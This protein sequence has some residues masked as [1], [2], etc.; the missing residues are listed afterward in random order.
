TPEEHLLKADAALSA[1]RY[2]EAAESY[3][4][5][6]DAPETRARAELNLRQLQLET[7]HYAAAAAPAR[8]AEGN[9]EMAQRT[10]LLRAQALLAV[11]DESAALAILEKEVSPQARLLRGEVLINSGKRQAAK[12]ILMS[13]IEDYN[14]D[15]IR[16][17]DSDGMSYVGRAAHLL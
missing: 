13:I 1:G 7:G 16:D 17:S 11:G 3:Q 12:P 8:H 4:V 15:R 5:A 6:L 9:Q 10:A 14:E 2:E